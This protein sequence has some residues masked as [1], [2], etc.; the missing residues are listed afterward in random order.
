MSDEL[1]KEA[2]GNYLDKSG[3]FEGVPDVVRTKAVEEADEFI[4]AGGMNLMF[5]IWDARAKR[6]QEER[7]YEK[8]RLAQTVKVRFPEGVRDIVA[9]FEQEDMW[10]RPH[11]DGFGR[12]RLVPNPMDGWEFKESI[13]IEPNWHAFQV[14]TEADRARSERLWR[15]EYQIPYRDRNGFNEDYR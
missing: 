2:I 1:R 8:A 3:A 7:D 6:E 10:L 13:G 12:F 14:P 9:T 15:E 11:Q 5:S 4:K